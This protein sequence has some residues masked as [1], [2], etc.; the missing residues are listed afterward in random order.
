MCQF[1]REK[2]FSS[3]RVMSKRIKAKFRT[4]L[5][6]VEAREQVHAS[7]GI[8]APHVAQEPRSKRVVL[9]S[10]QRTCEIYH[11]DASEKCERTRVSAL[12]L[13]TRPE[14]AVLSSQ[15][16]KWAIYHE[17]ASDKCERM[18]VPMLKHHM[19]HRNHD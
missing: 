15:Q 2:R 14:R 4:E 16:R 6:K 10:R 17:D 1:Q 9:S 18:R 7:V 12:K 3:S 5:S 13:H 11:E 19:L 8:Q